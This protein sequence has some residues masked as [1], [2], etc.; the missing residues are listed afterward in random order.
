M[1][2]S[3]NAQKMPP[4][5]ALFILYQYLISIKIHSVED[6]RLPRGV[7]TNYLAKIRRKLSENEENW[8]ET[9]EGG[10]SKCY[11]VDP[12]LTLRNRPVSQ[13]VVYRPLC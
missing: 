12:P 6:P 5:G 10:T 7:P 4:H 3:Y 2:N 1:D 8:T 9:E 13:T 11:Y